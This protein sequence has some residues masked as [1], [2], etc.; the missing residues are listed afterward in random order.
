VEPRIGEPLPRARDAYVDP[1]KLVEYALDPRSKKGRDKAVVFER[2]LGISMRHA[3]YLRDVVLAALP[4]H[5][6]SD[7]RPATT[8]KNVTTWEVLLPVR[9]ING[10]TLP[11]VTGWRVDGDRP[12]LVTIRVRRKPSGGR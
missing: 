9:G 8:S 2:A 1:R 12:E 3:L 11:V 10:R 4:H 5:S 7:V 6:V